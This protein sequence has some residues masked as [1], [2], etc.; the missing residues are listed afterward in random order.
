MAKPIKMRTQQ[1]ERACFSN[2][3]DVLHEILGWMAQIPPA[4]HL[5]LSQ[6]SVPWYGRQESKYVHDSG[7]LL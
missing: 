6:S 7:S 4:W 1:G 3:K 5:K 2:S